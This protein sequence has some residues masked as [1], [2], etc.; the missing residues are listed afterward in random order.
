MWPLALVAEPSGAA[1]W[2]PAAVA[3]DGKSL[4][5]VYPAPNPSA[6]SQWST[7][8]AA[9]RELP[10]AGT[11]T[12][13]GVA[14][15][16]DG[17]ALIAGVDYGKN[18][19]SILRVPTAGGPTDRNRLQHRRAAQFRPP[20]RDGSRI[21]YAVDARINEVWTLDLKAALSAK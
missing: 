12:R 8:T 16:L 13:G 9:L 7:S 2:R 17:G 4:A 11:V 20:S 21:A 6:N 14:W 5:L 15:T 10:L 18:V 19:S 1:L 3:P